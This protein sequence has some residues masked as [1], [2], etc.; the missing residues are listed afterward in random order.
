MMV[1]ERKGVWWMAGVLVLS[2]AFLCFA[3]T[4]E[5]PWRGARAK[6]ILGAVVV[7]LIA[8]SS[9]AYTL[10]PPSSHPWVTRAFFGLGAVTATTCTIMLARAMWGNLATLGEDFGV[11]CFIAL[12][13]AAALG[14]SV[15]AWW[16]FARQFK[17]P[18]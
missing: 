1:G 18:K 4:R 13:L 5:D 9:L 16:A 12:I 10:L 3:L 7:A 11:F 6:G 8:L 2:V 14:V 15:Y 17:R